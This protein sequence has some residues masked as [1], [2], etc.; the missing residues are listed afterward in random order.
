MSSEKIPKK[1]ILAVI[2]TGIMSLCGVLVETSMNIAFP[3]LM[4]EFKIST[5]TVQWMTS[6]YLL[7]VAIIV[8]LSAVLKSSFKTKQLF[9]CANLC[10]ILG[11]LVDTLAPNFYLL[12]LGRAIQ[13]VGTGI[14]LPLMF[15]IIMEQVPK[16]RVGF[17]M[18][19]GNMIT[20][21]APALGPTLGGLVVTSIGW[22]YVFILLL[23]LLVLSLFWGLYG[24]EQKSPIVK[25]KV[26]L[27]SFALIALIFS[28]LVYGFSNL[29]S[30]PLFSWQVLYILLIG[31]AGIIALIFRT[32]Q[33]EVPILNLKLLKN[34]RFSAHVLG[35][36]LTQILSLSFAFLLPNYIQLVNHNTALVAGMLV[37]PSGIIG[38]FFGPLGGQLFDRYGARKPILLGISMCLLVILAFYVKGLT[39][40]NTFI[41]VVY[42]FYMAGMG[43][44]MGTVMTNA[45]GQLDIKQITQGNAIM[46]TL[47]QFAGAMGT[48]LAA[49]IVNEGQN[50]LTKTAGTMLGTHHAFLFMLIIVII[51]WLTYFIFIKKPSQD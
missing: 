39:I 23:P 44:T 4:T 26:D 5:S 38:A 21:I 49:T 14:A 41:A 32:N 40:S 16:S 30:Q 19:L 10:F 20:G 33:L 35:F 29:S 45:L 48:S 17:M 9:L 22:R 8:P 11:L 51:I 7:I 6:I 24:I 3:T 34:I 18:G 28:S 37:F 27:P 25:Q 42:I 36:F 15:N 50:D 13:G 46:N 2:A 47:Q 1:V 43:M 31:L 12:L